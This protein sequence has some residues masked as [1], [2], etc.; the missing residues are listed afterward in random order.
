[1]SA[2]V[3]DL[4]RRASTLDEIDRATLAG[5]LLESLEHEIDRDIESAWQ[6]EIAR[7]LADLDADDGGLVPWEE[8]KAELRK[9]YGAK[10]PD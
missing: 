4:L 9:R 3:G 7:R 2:P 1:M 8:L 6:D 10:A 5:L